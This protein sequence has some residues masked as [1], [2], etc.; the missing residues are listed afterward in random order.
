[1]WRCVSNILI[2]GN[3]G[4]LADAQYAV[5]RAIEADVRNGVKWSLAMDHATYANILS[6]R[7]LSKE[8]QENLEKAKDIFQ[9]CG[10]EGWAK[11]LGGGK[12]AI[13]ESAIHSPRAADPFVVP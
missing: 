9:K 6:K 12:F 1:V 7:K 3:R 8:S 10:A 13:E 5:E 4:A 2:Y 11:R